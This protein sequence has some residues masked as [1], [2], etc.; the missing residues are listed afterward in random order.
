VC[1]F[2]TPHKIITDQGT[3][4]ESQLIQALCKALQIAKART[5]A[6]QPQANG[7]VESI[8]RKTN[9]S[10]LHERTPQRLGYALKHGN[11]R[12]Q[13]RKK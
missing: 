3:N 10:M 9:T 4:F 1:R 8:N 7:Q 2:G 6:H 5:T 13:Y 11:V 12:L